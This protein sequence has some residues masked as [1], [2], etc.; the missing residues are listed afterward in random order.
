V[1]GARHLLHVD[2]PQVIINIIKA[3][4]EELKK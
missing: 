2:Q 3:A 4:L 1:E